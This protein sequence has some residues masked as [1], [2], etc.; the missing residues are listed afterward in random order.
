MA[1]D[2]HD[3]GPVRSWRA[4]TRFCVEV[5][6]DL[7]VFD[8][9]ADGADLWLGRDGAAWR[10]TAERSVLLHRGGPAHGGGRVTSPMPGTVLSVHVEPGQAVTPGQRLVVVEA[11]K[12]EHTVTAGQTGTVSQVLVRAGDPVR[13]D[14]PLVV[15]EA[16]G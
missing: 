1:V 2:G 8:W 11:M 9:A 13:L 5:A 4:G 15:M 3:L 7:T 10:L 14:Q 16:A 12:M 6:G